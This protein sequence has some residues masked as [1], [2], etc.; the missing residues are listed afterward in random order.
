MGRHVGR[1][2]IVFLIR[3]YYLDRQKHHF[4][5]CCFKC[6]RLDN[7][8]HEINRWSFYDL[9]QRRNKWFVIFH[10]KFDSKITIF[11]VFI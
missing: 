2:F 5:Y 7:I 6:E 9:N 1:K 3:S 10:K 8:L 4:S 11:P